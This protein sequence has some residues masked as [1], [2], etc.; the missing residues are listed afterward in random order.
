MHRSRRPSLANVRSHHPPVTAYS[1]WN[2]SHG[3]RLQG[4]NAQKASFKTTINVKQVGHAMYH[5]DAFNEDY[6]I[7]LPPLHIEGLVVGAPYVEL[8]SATY[9]QSSSGYTAK[10]EYSGRGWVS[11]KS[12]SFSAT[13]YPEDKKKEPIYTAEGQWTGKF[14]FKDAKTKQVRSIFPH[15]FSL[16]NITDPCLAGHRHLRPRSNQADRPNHRPLRTTRPL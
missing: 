10:I 8:N 3:V 16:A 2:S 1:I 14:S 7:T 6:L 13:I 4:Y 15:I 11:G 5:I 12:N 9:I